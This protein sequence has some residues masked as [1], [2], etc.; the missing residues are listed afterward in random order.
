MAR[1]RGAFEEDGELGQTVEG[2]KV[3]QARILALVL[4][5]DIV[6]LLQVL[7]EQLQL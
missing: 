3:K 1:P 7:L 6:L 2:G 4:H 5:D